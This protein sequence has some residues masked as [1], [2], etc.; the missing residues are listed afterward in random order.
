[1]R[2]VF[3]LEPA[4]F[5][6]RTAE[7]RGQIMF[8]FGASSHANEIAAE[9]EERRELF[10]SAYVTAPIALDRLIAEQRAALA[11]CQVDGVGFGTPAAGV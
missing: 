4:E 5:E 2:S 10:L 3:F 6:R 1:V 9:L 7:T 11:R 8:M